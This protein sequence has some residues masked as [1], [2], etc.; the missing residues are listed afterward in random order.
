MSLLEGPRHLLA[1]KNAIYAITCFYEF[2]NTIPS[3]ELMAECW[4][5]SAAGH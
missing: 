4:S 3:Q 5:S 2:S 1:S